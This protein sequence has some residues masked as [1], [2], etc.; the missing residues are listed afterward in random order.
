MKKYQKI[1]VIIL[2]CF[3]LVIVWYH[4]KTPITIEQERAREVPVKFHLDR[5]DKGKRL[6]NVYIPYKITI[7]NN[8]LNE[9]T[10][11]FFSDGGWGFGNNLIYNTQGM[12]LNDYRQ[13]HY[14]EKFCDTYLKYRRTIFPFFSRTFYYYKKHVFFEDSL[15][16]NFRE[17]EYA[18]Y[19]KQLELLSNDLKIPIKKSIIDSLYK[20]DKKK[21]LNI[22]FDD[23]KHH[24]IPIFIESRIDTKEQR[25]V[26][27]C[28]SIKSMN[29]EESVIY[30]K[31][32]L[33]TKQEFF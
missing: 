14:A 20:S 10:I 30:L 7:Y 32:Y 17:F 31:K 15:K 2:S 24:V 23:Y 8:K 25:L 16:Y 33:M 3:L 4:L 5:N 13:V 21:R 27:I 29:K 22:H 6:I 12:E 18:E 26:D 19:S 9:I 28:D 11:T 1:L